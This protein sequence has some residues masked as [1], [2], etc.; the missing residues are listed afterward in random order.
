MW[1][2]SWQSLTRIA[3]TA[4]IGYI[5]L[6]VLLRTFGKRT[7]SKL[8]AFDFVITIALGSL[9]A[10]LVISDSVPLVN[11]VVALAVLIG[12]QWLASTLYVRSP[13]F[14]ALIKGVPELVY[15]KG[16]YLDGVLRRVRITHEDIDAAMR[17]GNVHS[18]ETAV[19]LETDG[20]LTAVE[21]PPDALPG[22]LRSVRT[23]GSEARQQELEA[24]R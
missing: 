9:F 13:R 23:P 6:I 19:V 3:T 11:G 7:L 21:V 10:T 8:N 12:L 20:T 24:R 2:D 5:A 4:G 18:T 22:A 14:Q 16:F 1:F 17:D 15:W